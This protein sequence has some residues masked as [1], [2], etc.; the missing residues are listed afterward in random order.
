MQQLGSVVPFIQRFALLQAVIALQAN[1]LAL[2]C[3]AKRLGQL[4]FTDAGFALQ[5]QRALQLEG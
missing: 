2:Q 5:Q 1:E 4:G 3:D